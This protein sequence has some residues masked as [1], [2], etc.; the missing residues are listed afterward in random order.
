MASK[1]VQDPRDGETGARWTQ[2]EPRLR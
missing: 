2:P 1:F